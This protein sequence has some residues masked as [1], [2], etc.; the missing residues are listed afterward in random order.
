MRIIK[1]VITFS[2]KGNNDIRDLTGPVEQRLA[3]CRLRSGV[4]TIFVPGS[5][6]G[7]TTIEYEEGLVHD[8]AS[9]IERLIPS[10]FSYEHDRKWGDGNGFAHVRSALIGPS[11]TVPFN[12]GKLELG[13]WQQI[14]F[15]DFDNRPRSRTVILQ[16]IGE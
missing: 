15:I 5:T 16:F 3:A 11:L 4:V 12:E 8:L 7:I 1:D 2:T 6:A 14:I 10:D 9:A 13:T